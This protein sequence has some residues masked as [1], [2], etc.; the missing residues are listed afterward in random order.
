MVLI[1]NRPSASSSVSSSVRAAPTLRS[2]PALR[3]FVV[4]RRTR[5]SHL[6]RACEFRQLCSVAPARACARLAG[7][8]RRRPSDPAGSHL[9]AGRRRRLPDAAG[10]RALAGIHQGAASLN[11]VLRAQAHP[12]PAPLLSGPAH[13]ALRESHSVQRRSSDLWCP[14]A[15]VAWTRLFSGISLMI[16]NAESRTN[17][18]EIAA[19]IYRVRTPVPLPGTSAQFSFNQ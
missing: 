4:P 14:S 1:G 6:L 16:T 12:P 18:Q 19:G 11:T 5:G 2:R 10:A 3:R 17:I 9:V 8:R 7:E 15:S 13:S